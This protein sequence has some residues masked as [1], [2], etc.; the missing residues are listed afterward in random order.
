MRS[1]VSVP[2]HGGAGKEWQAETRRAEDRCLVSPGKEKT[3]WCAQA[4][5]RGSSFIF[6][7]IISPCNPLHSNLCPLGTCPAPCGQATHLHQALAA[8]SPG[9]T[10]HG[11]QNKLDYYFYFFRVPL[12]TGCEGEDVSTAQA[13][14]DNGALKC[15]GTRKQGRC[16]VPDLENVKSHLIS[17]LNRQQ[18]S[19][20]DLPPIK[21][22]AIL[23]LCP[24]NTI[25]R[26][27]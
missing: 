5:P 2:E 9:S 20:A 15:C 21:T 25:V 24:P 23:F 27:K 6:Q 26:F 8:A 11:K 4:P 3:T 14:F 10:A 13:G 7:N 22:C 18:G 1:R 19:A 17:H 16:P 12:R